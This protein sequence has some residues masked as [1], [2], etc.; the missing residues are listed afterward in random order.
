MDVRGSKLGISS[1]LFFA[2]L[3]SSLLGCK[4]DGLIGWKGETGGDGGITPSSVGPGPA[5]APTNAPPNPS[6]PPGTPARGIADPEMPADVLAILQGRCGGCH[7]YG[8]GDQAGWGSV[9]DVSRMIAAD[10][11]V[12]GNPDAS[13]MIDRIA[14]AGDMPPRGDRV[15]SADVQILKRWIGDLKRTAN[16]PLSDTDVLDEISV[17]QLRLRDR[18]ADY[19]YVSFA[20]FAG[21]GRS[22]KEMEAVR[23]VFT[24]TI[25][26]LSRKGQIADTPTIDQGKSIFRIRLSDLGWNEALWD[27]L[28]GFYPYCIKSDNVAHEGLYAQLGT[29]APVV[30]GDW[31]LAT[32]TKPPLYDLLI[33]L[34]KTVDELGQ[35]L[36]ININNDINHPGLAEPDNLIRVGFRKSGVALHNRL[37]ER[38]LGNAGQY[39]W[40]SYDFDSNE[41]QADL[42]ANPLGPVDRDQQNFVHRFQHAGGEVIFTMP[43]GLQGY[44]LVNAVGTSIAEAPINIVRDPRRR[45]GAVENGISCFGC[46]GINGMIKPRDLDEVARYAETHIADFDGRELNEIDSTYPRVLRPDVFA[47]DGDR[48]K[49]F[50]KAIPGG[51]PASP[52]GEYGDFV[53]M[54]GQYESN[55]GFH[56]AAAEFYEEYE[57][58]RQRVLANDFQNDALPRTATSPLVTRDDFVCVWRDLVQKV[59]A[60][61]LFCD[62]TFDAAAVANVCSSGRSSQ[63]K[64][65]PQPQPPRTGTG[66]RSGSTGGSSGQNS[67][68]GGSSR[69]TGG[70]GGSSR[71]TGG[72]GGSSG[73]SADAGSSDG[74]L[75]CTRIDGRRV[76]R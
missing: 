9:L 46:H 45:T 18:S 20:H 11:I 53:A 74:G 31:F 22:D 29:E 10:I 40:V 41:G 62:K 65:Q 72:A 32:A 75:Q 36:G 67:G 16:Q 47:A 13:R 54:V 3:S 28:T 66:G 8:Q 27:T 33:D 2:G 52:D 56:G 43:N 1:L 48:Y 42:L 76:C 26:S 7:T 17:D 44:M 37:L 38:H 60:N 34:P 70:A 61:A 6:A 19:R 50:T 57:S 21:E 14:V 30:R 4:A 5:P 71:G 25:N 73:G 12:P 49:G 68:T 39:L 24:F 51:G 63:P 58:F 55:V 69:G 35:R 15:A 23:A 59:R 64:P